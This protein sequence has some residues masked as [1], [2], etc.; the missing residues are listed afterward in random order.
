MYFHIVTIIKYTCFSSMSFAVVVGSQIVP[1]LVDLTKSDVESA[2]STI[3]SFNSSEE[4]RH[5]TYSRGVLS[6]N[7]AMRPAR[8]VVYCDTRRV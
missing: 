2:L 8:S 3:E 7:F 4:G 6:F 5:R 1:S